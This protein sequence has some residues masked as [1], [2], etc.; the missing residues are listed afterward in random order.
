MSKLLDEIRE[1]D[2]GYALAN[3]G[4]DYGMCGD[5]PYDFM[6]DLEKAYQFNL[7]ADD[8]V[9]AIKVLES[10]SICINLEAVHDAIDKAIDILKPHAAAIEAAEKGGA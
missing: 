9:E 8:N 7:K 1:K 4:A 2:G 10:V 3:I 5:D 6:C